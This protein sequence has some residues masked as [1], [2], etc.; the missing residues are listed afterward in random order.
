M[1]FLLALVLATT[2]TLVWAKA[3]FEEDFMEELFNGEF[4]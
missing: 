2:L 1:K 3:S 4:H